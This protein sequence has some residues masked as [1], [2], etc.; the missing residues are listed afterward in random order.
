MWLMF[1]S[2]ARR[3]PGKSAVA[4][5]TSHLR[6]CA[7]LLLI[8]AAFQLY[9]ENAEI[10]APPTPVHVPAPVA[11]EP[12]EAEKLPE[13]E[14]VPQAFAESEEP[15]V[16][17]AF[18]DGVS[19]YAEDAE[20]G[21]GNLIDGTD[22]SYS[23][24][25]S[26]RVSQGANA[27]HLANPGFLIDNWFELDVDIDVAAGT[28]LYFQSRL[29][30]ATTTQFAKVQISTDGGASWPTT[31]Y[32]QAGTGGSGEGSFALREVDL[33]TSY[34][35]Q[36]IRIR[37]YYD[38]TGGSYYNQVTADVGW[39]IDDIQIGSEFEKSLYSIGDPT[40]SE[41]LYVE[42]INRARED[43]LLEAN[44]LA[45][46]TDS[47]ILGAYSYFGVDTADI[48]EQFTWYVNNGCMDQYAQPL[49]FQAQLVQMAQLHT[50]D[51]FTNEFQSH[52]SSSSPPAPFQPGDGISERRSRVGYSGGI[53]ENVF[54]YADSVEHGH[55]GF[56]VD[57]GSRTNTSSPC[58]N[59]DFVGQ[60]MQNP[61]GHRIS[62]HSNTYNEVGVGVINDSNGSVGPQIVTQDFG[63][64]S[65]TYITGV[66][67]DDDDSNGMYSATSE[68]NHEGRGGIRVDVDG[69][70]VYT[71]ST[72]S[73]AY[74]IPVAGDGTYTL[75]FSG[76]TI[77]TYSTQ[78]TVTGGLNVKV[79]HNPVDLSRYY[80]WAEGY[81]LTGGPDDDDDKDGVANIIE[82]LLDGMD[83]TMADAGLLP[84]FEKSPD[85]KMRLTINKQTGA[86]D[87]TV[88]VMLSTDLTGWTA[89][90]VMANTTVE[91]DN[92]SQTVIAIDALHD[93]MF[94][95][96]VVEFIE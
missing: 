44:R 3:S 71:L 63:S 57:W 92:A 27:F 33:G 46:I 20:S 5:G 69:S 76:S 72:A 18:G 48:I 38:Y 8:L 31:V 54:A 85:G 78:V 81:G 13:S 91:V 12:V 88:T 4:K 77:E 42:V 1:S 80:I 60:G 86:D 68:S 65:A 6:G 11:P 23:L 82:S 84:N 32:S 15:I 40:P 14:P 94:A 73:G 29:Q 34:L 28:K 51:M 2:S 52:T 21:A 55:A 56:N 59:A 58:Y 53:G 49:A 67:Y 22:A 26:D 90:G 79:D 9:G 87:V 50:L 39:L 66:I 95:R 17:K 89:A 75:S 7:L 19:V 64:T 30:Y 45:A 41:V 10:L 25:Q 93:V 24:I 70:P 61:A 37:F 36:Q 16:P 47:D 35:G 43:A 83:P 74:A 62:I 96:L